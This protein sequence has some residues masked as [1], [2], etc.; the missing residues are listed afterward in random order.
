[1]EQP[2]SE[3][4]APATILIGYMRV[5]KADDS[6]VFDLQHDALVAAGVE[7][8]RIYEDRVS[9]K[10]EQRPGLDACLRALQPGNCLVVWKLD[11]L[12][13]SLGHL[14]ELMERFRNTKVDFQV[15]TGEGSGIDTTTNDGR[16]MFHLFGA[17]AEY[18]RGLI[19]E[20]TIA[21]LKAAR[22][23]GRLGGQPSKLTPAKLRIAQAAMRDPDRKIAELCSELGISRQTLYRHVDPKGGLRADGEKILSGSPR[24][25]V[26]GMPA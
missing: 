7:P 2:G 20:R 6:Q 10:L 23:R 22:A 9:G 4:R 18:E 3:S 21:G 25:Q 8:S 26:K 1:M 24:R 19:K 13:R 15:L 16:L 5:S 14:I 12:G 17:L 11:R